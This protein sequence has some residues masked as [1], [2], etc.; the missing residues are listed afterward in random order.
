MTG[1]ANAAKGGR[2]RGGSRR[3]S[4][5]SRMPIQIVHKNPAS[6]HY[7]ENKDVRINKLAI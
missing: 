3:G 2:G 4:F 6:A 5:G 7:Y 1:E